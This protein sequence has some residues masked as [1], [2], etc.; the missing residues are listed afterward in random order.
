MIVLIH[1]AG[2]VFFS[3]L[4][5]YTVHCIH[6]YPFGGLTIINKDLNAPIKHELLIACGGFIFQILIYLSLICPFF[7]LHTKELI[8]FYNSTIMFFNLLP[9]IP[10]DGSIILNTFL[11]KVLTFKKA[12][13]WQIIL[14]FIGILIFFYFNYRSSLNNYLICTFLIYKTYLSFKDTNFIYNRFLLE[15][16]LKNFSF[17][18]IS[19]KRGSLE[20]LKKDTYQYFLE[21]NKIISE[22]DKLKQK[23]RQ[24][25]IKTY[26]P[27]KSSLNKK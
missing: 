3:V 15:R 6:I 16:F 7:T 24:I 27:K 23:F 2:H 18:H 14:S 4:L 8:F 12:Y 13:Y 25:P 10:L 11:N 22:K 5:G 21:E 17:P 1:E 20:I 19:T 9:I 26:E